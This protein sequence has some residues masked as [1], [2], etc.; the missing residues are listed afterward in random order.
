MRF[1]DICD[2]LKVSGIA[3]FKHE[4][5]LLLQKFC[6][7]SP[8]AL[9][10]SST[11]DFDNPQLI[12]AVKRRCEHYPLQYIL[13]EW[14][15][16]GERYKVSEACLIPRADTEILVEEAIRS[17]PSGAVFADLCTGSGCIAISILAHRNDCSA[18]AVDISDA[19]LDLAK[20][21]ADI[22]GVS[23]R[24]SFFHGD[25]LSDLS[26]LLNGEQL[27]DAIIS[28]PPYI[29]TDVID[30]LSLEV[31]NEPLIALDGGEDGLNFYRAIL[32]NQNK[33]LKN[34]GFIAFEIGF[35]QAKE[36]KELA[37][38]HGFD[39]KIIKDYGGCDRV[40]FLT[41]SIK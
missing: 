28:N 19:A 14:F 27:F 36:M 2:Q 24:L 7:V 17:L 16:Y 32:E 11:V 13:G 22:N 31:K 26:S 20:E 37:L 3:D 35:D 5:S 34:D 15:F 1:S 38:F 6:G 21:N 8:S 18:V 4:A 9:I 40:A 25:V 12:S 39:C 41:R 30:T 23:N 10:S 29:R 33:L